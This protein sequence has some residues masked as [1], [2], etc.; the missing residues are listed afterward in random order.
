MADLPSANTIIDDEAGGFGGGTGY[1]VVFA[2]VEK[3]ADLTPRVFSSAK[4][5]LSQ[6]G[7]TPGASYVALHIEKTRKPVI[8]VGLPTATAGTI[9][10]QNSSGV[11]GSSAVSVAAGANGVLEEVDASIEVTKGG[12]IGTD[13]IEFSLS[14]DGGKTSKKVRLGTANSYTIPYVGLVLNFGAGT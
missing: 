9:G 11:T 13:P 8:Y 12:T 14:L 5:L 6:H 10:R 3:N 2:C 1:C 4:A 7:Y